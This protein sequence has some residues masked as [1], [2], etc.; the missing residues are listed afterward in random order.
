MSGGA[1]INPLKT[2][3]GHMGYLGRSQRAVSRRITA[4]VCLDAVQ[5]EAAIEAYTKEARVSAAAANSSGV[6]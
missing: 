1:E 2:R 4:G 5:P 3:Y 6:V